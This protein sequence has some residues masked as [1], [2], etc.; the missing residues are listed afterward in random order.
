MS[1]FTSRSAR[2][3][4]KMSCTAPKIEIQCT[5]SKLWRQRFSSISVPCWREESKKESKKEK[6]RRKKKKK[7][8]KKRLLH[9]QSNIETSECVCAC[10]R[11]S[12][13]A[14]EMKPRRIGL[15]PVYDEEDELELLQ[16]S[17]LSLLLLP[18]LLLSLLSLSLEESEPDDDDDDDDDESV[19]AVR[20][21]FVAALTA[22]R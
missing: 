20:L 18:S 4:A 2:V 13:H 8:K 6:K 9:N 11:V 15:L 3:K 10:M 17:L 16:L 7:K 22:P 12:S 21:G 5:G 14:L 19:L 1:N